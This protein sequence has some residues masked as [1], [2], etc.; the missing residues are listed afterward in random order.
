MIERRRAP[1]NQAGMNRRRCVKGDPKIMTRR[2]MAAPVR[3]VLGLSVLVCS[4]LPVQSQAL[5]ASRGDAPVIQG[6]LTAEDSGIPLGTGSVTLYGREQREL[7]TVFTD[8]SGRYSLQAPS[9]GTYRLRAER[10]GYHPVERGP[11]TLQATDTLT[12]DFQLAPSPLLLDSVLV[13]VR[14]QGRPIGSGEQLVYGRLLDDQSGE[15][16]PQG[17]IRLLEASGS[18]AGATLSDEE[19]LFWLVSP[20]AG[21]YRLQAERIGYRTSTGPELYLM[22]GDTLGLDFYLSVEAVLLNPI[23]VRATARDLRNRYDLTGM[24]DFL[25]RYARFS[26]NGFGTFY[27]RDS[28]AEWEDRSVSTA[29]ML[30]LT[31]APIWDANELSGTVRMTAGC[32]P[33]YYLDGFPWP[34]GVPIWTYSPD[35]LEAVEV[36][37]RPTIPAEFL[38]GFPCGVVAYWT[39]RAPDPGTEAPRWKKWAVGLGLLGLGILATIF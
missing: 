38:R 23:V 30:A 10:I 5:Q 29:G 20:S 14:R 17:L 24:E 37:E 12:V 9:P 18:S 11:F 3:T 27:T 7:Q 36:Y 25:G 16:I 35:M 33:H 15:A 21:T 31:S 28:L 26:T 2:P 4:L 39:R 13:S 34:S 8:D 1:S 22:L 32:T 6:V 19:G